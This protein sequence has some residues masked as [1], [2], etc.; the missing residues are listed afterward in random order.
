M[1]EKL[2]FEIVALKE[3]I[4]LLYKDIKLDYIKIVMLKDIIIELKGR[5]HPEH[6]LDD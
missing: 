4:E 1:Y 3:K 5:I 6:H 2:N